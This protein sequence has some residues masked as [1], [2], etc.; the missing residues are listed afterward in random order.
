MRVE[1]VGDASPPGTGI[2]G[3][4]NPIRPDQT[5]APFRASL[6]LPRAHHLRPGIVHEVD[7]AETTMGVHPDLPPVPVWG[8]GTQGRIV[9]P[10][11]LL[12]VAAGQETWVRWRNF[13]PGSV[14]PGDTTQP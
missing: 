5:L 10:G 9:S 3:P 13:L 12:E 8:F 6:S 7:I 14:R 4:P 11:P 2:T 1:A